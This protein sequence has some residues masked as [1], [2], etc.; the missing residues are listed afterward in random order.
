MRSLLLATALGCAI[1]ASLIGSSA[2]HENHHQAYSAPPRH[3]S[4]GP[5]WNWWNHHGWHFSHRHQNFSSGSPNTSW[6]NRN[7]RHGHHRYRNYS[8]GSPERHLWKD[9]NWHGGHW[10]RGDHDGQFG[11]WWIVG[12]NWY[13]FD[14][15]TYPYPPVIV[16]TE[17]PPAVYEGR[18]YCRSFHGDAIVAGTDRPFFGDACLQ[19]NGRWRAVG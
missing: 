18:A 3:Y 1:S 7:D 17:G 5:D 6:W 12:N 19:P 8:S 14:E 10:H 11:W 13:L 4:S 2:A 9:H 16:T 15:P